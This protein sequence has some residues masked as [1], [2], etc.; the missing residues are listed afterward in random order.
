MTVAS[1]AEFL[2]E[3]G[4]ACSLEVEGRMLLL[5][6]RGGCDALRQASLRRRLVTL[7]REAGFTHVAV[8]IRA[9][10]A[11]APVSGGQ[12]S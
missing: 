4:V 9:E 7:A 2:Q 10:L 11:D 3:A 12:S 6:P 1:L 8:E 5:V